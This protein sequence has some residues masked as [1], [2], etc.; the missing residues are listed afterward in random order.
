[1]KTK[2]LV[3]SII[4]DDLINTKLVY[5]L[6][7][8]GLQADHYCLHASITVLKLL[9]IKATPQRWE[10]IY[11]DYLDMTRKVLQISIEE[12]PRQVDALALEIFDFLKQ[13]KAEQK[14]LAAQRG[15]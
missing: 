5:S 8:L 9:R 15:T 4:K 2:T 1:M 11:T 13:C 12:F 6:N 3:L 14:A 7:E 10:K